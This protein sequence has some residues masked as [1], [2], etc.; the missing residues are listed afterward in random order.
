MTPQEV[1]H[2]L[3]IA[4]FTLWFIPTF[5]GLPLLL[6]ALVFGKDVERRPAVASMTLALFICGVSHSMLL[7]ASK[8]NLAHIIP[9]AAVCSAQAALTSGLDVM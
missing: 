7:F 4:F 9:S 2:P 6:A 8:F 5:S 1:S 3:S